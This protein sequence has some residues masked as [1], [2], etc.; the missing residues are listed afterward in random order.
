MTGSVTILGAGVA[1]LS[2]AAELTQRGVSCTIHDPGGAPGAHGC[3]WW[4]GGM[5]APF[6]EAES[7]D[8]TVIRLGIE[9]AEW[10]QGMGAQ[11]HHTGTLVLAL[12]RDHAE[13]DRF[14]R[15]TRKHEQLS[16]RSIAELEPELEGRF[17]RGLFFYSESHLTPRQALLALTRKLQDR[18]ITIST[19]PASVADQ[20]LIVDARGLAARDKLSDLRGVRGEMLVIRCPE[21]RLTRTIRLLHPRIPLYIVP[22][23]DGVY[24]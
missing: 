3:S 7:A 22:R 14:A 18:G 16:A 11:V 5:L 19:G 17:Q 12:A 10:W 4:A 6:C 1:G 20:G 15:L 9:A 8:E 13:L 2:I 24:M 23:G 21:V